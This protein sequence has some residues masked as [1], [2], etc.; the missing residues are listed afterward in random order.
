V[1]RSFISRLGRDRRDKHLV[2]AIIGMA[3]AL[4]L[5]VVAEGVETERQLL[6]LAELGCSV[7]QGHLFSGA[8]PAPRLVSLLEAKQ[9]HEK[10]AVA[11]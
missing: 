8:Q 11:V 5:T 2:E 10:I 7:A 1:D 3:R 6:L 9:R 4:N